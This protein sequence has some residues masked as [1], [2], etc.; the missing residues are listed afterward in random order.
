VAQKP[1]P[2][3]G[4]YDMPF[5]VPGYREVRM[6]SDDGVVL[7]EIRVHE[8]A[9]RAQQKDL[10]PVLRAWRKLICEREVRER[11]H[12]LHLITPEPRDEKAS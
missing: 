9:Q 6:V 5:A 7:V 8:R 12:G 1:S 10:V 11:R 2:T 3:D 4:V